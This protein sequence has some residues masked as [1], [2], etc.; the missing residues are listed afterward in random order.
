MVDFP[1]L[2]LALTVADA[3]QSLSPFEGIFFTG[4]PGPITPT[5][6]GPDVRF[7]AVDA[8]GVVD[9]D[10]PFE[11]T[12]GAIIALNA[13]QDASDP[14]P[15]PSGMLGSAVA[16]GGEPPLALMPLRLERDRAWL[17]PPPVKPGNRRLLEQWRRQTRGI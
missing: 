16:P 15:Q 12:G 14:T 8:Q 7:I 6:F 3:P 5:A 1:N 13:N 11:A 9:V 10:A 4:A 17:H 2:P